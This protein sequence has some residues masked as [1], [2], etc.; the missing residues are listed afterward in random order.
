MTT[1]QTMRIKYE[2]APAHL[3]AHTKRLRTLTNDRMDRRERTDLVASAISQS[4][5]IRTK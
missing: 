5:G 2:T 3:T 4:A 1:G